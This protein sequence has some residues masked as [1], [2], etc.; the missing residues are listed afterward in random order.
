MN[1]IKNYLYKPGPAMPYF[2]DR[3]LIKENKASFRIKI[4]VN[5]QPFIKISMIIPAGSFCEHRRDRM[6]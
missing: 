6:F 5:K 4:E 3:K 2:Y 1:E